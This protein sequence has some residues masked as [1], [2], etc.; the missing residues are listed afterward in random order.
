[1]P[2]PFPR[3]ESHL[4]DDWTFLVLLFSLILLAWVQVSEPGQ[5][6]KLALNA[7]NIRLMRQ[8]MREEVQHKRSRAA[9]MIH[10]VLSAGLLVYF[11]LI[12]F[13]DDRLPIKGPLL[14][15]LVSAAIAVAGLLRNLQITLTMHLVDGDYSL[16]EYRHSTFLLWRLCGLLMLPILMLAA[17]LDL[18]KASF[19][20]ACGL[21]LIACLFLYRW[22]RGVIH[23]LRAGVPPSYIFFYICTLEILPLLAGAKAIGW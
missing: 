14:F 1:M 18:E 7:F 8:D 22:A 23:A 9:F 19:A 10:A 5:F 4:A 2:V 3:P 12:S 6:R 21:G 15:A 16:S 20:I 13:A 17:Y 11:A